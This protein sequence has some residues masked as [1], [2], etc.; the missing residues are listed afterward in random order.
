M[1]KKIEKLLL[2]LTSLVMLSFVG[3]C[4][5]GAV[6][7]SEEPEKKQEEKQE[8]VIVSSL[9][10]DLAS[11]ILD[12]HIGDNYNPEKDVLVIAEYSDGTKENVTKKCT[13]TGFNSSV[14]NDN[15]EISVE[16]VF[17]GEKSTTSYFI[18][19]S[20][21]VQNLIDE[22]YTSSKSNF[23]MK[24]MFKCEFKNNQINNLD[25]GEYYSLWFG[26][27]P[28]SDYECY[29]TKEPKPNHYLDRHDEAIKTIP[30]TGKEI[31]GGGTGGS[32][33]SFR[34]ND[35][36]TYTTQ[37]GTITIN[38]FQ[39]DFRYTYPV[40]G[41]VVYLGYLE[42]TKFTAKFYA[43]DDAYYYKKFLKE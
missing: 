15:L 12:Y 13:F 32:K 28:A 30:L 19:V 41:N 42:T 16:Y 11:T 26:Y 38:G 17:K 34:S 24:G 10:V 25:E 14:E 2:V 33:S 7:S 21:T 22:G 5:N 31:I 40:T 36:Q 9:Y 8:E 3:S 27:R 35:A 4:S 43:Y 23:Y 37:D 6:D 18:T 1:I 20:K 29:Y 39:Q